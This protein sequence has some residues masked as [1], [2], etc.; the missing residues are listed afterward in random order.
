MKDNCHN[1]E[2][3][4]EAIAGSSRPHSV[5]VDHGYC[6]LED[7]GVATTD[8]VVSNYICKGQMQ[9]VMRGCPCL[10]AFPLALLSSTFCACR[11]LYTSAWGDLRVFAQSKLTIEDVLGIRPSSIQHMWPGLCSLRCLSSVYIVVRLAW[12]STLVLGTQS[13]QLMPRMQQRH[14]V[15][16]LFTFCSCLAQVVQLSLP[17]RRVLIMH[18]L[19]TAILVRVVSLGLYQTRVVGRPRVVAALLMRQLIQAS[20][21]KLLLM[22]EPRQVNWCT[23]SSMQ[24]SKVMT[25]G[26]STSWPS[27]LVFFR[28]MVSPKSLQTRENLSIRHCRSYEI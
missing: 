11:H 23:T 28:L 27:R 7:R 10:C 22:V 14:C 1:R 5:D 25:G 6:T 16:K 21:D 9:L 2:S 13:L 4:R 8:V 3:K 26:V 12:A 19:Y 24:L 20:K 17:Y 15:W 18:T